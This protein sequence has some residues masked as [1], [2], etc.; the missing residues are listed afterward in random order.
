MENWGILRTWPGEDKRHVAYRH[1]GPSTNVLLVDGHVDSIR[2]GKFP[3]SISSK[4][5]LAQAL[6]EHAP[7][8]LYADPDSWLSE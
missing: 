8:S 4:M 2:D 1:R 7:Y 3:H 5:P 6:A